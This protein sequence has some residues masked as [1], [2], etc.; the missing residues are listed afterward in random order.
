M[1][2]F[3]LNKNEISKTTSKKINK[4]FKMSKLLEEL[5]GIGFNN[6]ETKIKKKIEII[7]GLYNNQIK[8]LN[9]S[10]KFIDENLFERYSNELNKQSQLLLNQIKTKLDLEISNANA[11]QSKSD[12]KKNEKDLSKELKNIKNLKFKCGIIKSKQICIWKLLISE[13]KFQKQLTALQVIKYKN[14]LGKSE[15]IEKFKDDEK[16]L[17]DDKALSLASYNNW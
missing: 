4:I 16:S 15:F 8:Q 13:F 1:A 2:S 14:P 9:N 11:I 3:G 5:D 12:K 10:K 17:L 6:I 7:N